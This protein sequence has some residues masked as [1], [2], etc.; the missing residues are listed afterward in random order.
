[1]PASDPSSP[2]YP[3]RLA[4]LCA[5]LEEGK[6]GVGDY[7][8]TLARELARR[9]VRCDLLSLN[10]RDVADVTPASGSAG[11]EAGQ[12]V[13]IPSRLSPT[14][15]GRVAAR[16]LRLWQPD[17]VS[18]QFVGYGFQSKGIALRESFWLPRLL[19]PFRLE[20]MMHE[21]WIGLLA[22]DPPKDHVIGA[23]QRCAITRLIRRTSPAVIHTS[24]EVYRRLLG[25][26]GFEARLL[27]LFGNVPVGSESA[28]WLAEALKQA[29]GV[30][31]SLG[32]ERFW[33]FGLFGGIP[34]GWRCEPLLARIE[35]MAA[36]GGQTAIVVS[37][38]QIGSDTARLFSQWQARFATLRFAALGPRP[39][40]EVSQFLNTIDFG[41]SSYPLYLLGKS[42]SA[43]A[44]FE[45]G[46]PVIGAWGA[47][48]PESD[49]VYPPF[50][51]LVWA[52]DEGLENRIRSH[53]RLA[54]RRAS[55][56]E[57]VAA[58]FLADIGAA[59][60]MRAR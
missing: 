3:R 30:D 28:P 58:T 1:M 51:D 35:K 40:S 4:L 24:N 2:S 49:P 21:L 31:V 37:V 20:L 39:A 23:L 59:G 8:R 26:A 16:Y 43:A 15:R 9:R 5:G 44:M 22:S 12:L 41:L 53:K 27:P 25:Q 13:R 47:Q 50:L 10:D 57:Q 33:L 34:G 48:T 42:G 6:N 11:D 18:L 38:G 29:C 46:V 52:N 56:V 36:D 32:R 17:W 55:I 19:A 14:E 45:H 60:P 7:C 54:R